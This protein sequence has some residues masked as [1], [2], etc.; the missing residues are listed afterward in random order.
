MW[1]WCRLL[2]LTLVL[3]PALALTQPAPSPL[4]VSPDQVN[5]L[6]HLVYAVTVPGVPEP[7]V[8]VDTRVTVGLSQQAE[9]RVRWRTTASTAAPAPAT[10]CPGMPTISEAYSGPKLATYPWPDPWQPRSFKGMQLCLHTDGTV[11]WRWSDPAQRV[12]VPSPLGILSTGF[13]STSG[14]QTQIVPWPSYTLHLDRPSA[15]G[16]YLLWDVANPTP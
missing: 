9:H 3:A 4:G 5:W 1:C 10:T 14:R 13:A 12:T 15:E 6:G 11:R 8:T 2:T 16:G 7:L